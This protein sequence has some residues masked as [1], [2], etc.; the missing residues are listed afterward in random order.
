LIA[1]GLTKRPSAYAI[2]SRDRLIVSRV[3]ATASA[4]AQRFG[5]A[6]GDQAILDGGR[7]GFI[8]KERCEF[9][10]SAKPFLCQPY[11]ETLI[12]MSNF[13]EIR[14]LE[15]LR[16]PGRVVAAYK[17]RG[18]GNERLVGERR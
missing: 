16:T 6:R 18:C 15:S 13:V 11:G 12:S 7:T 1:L 8:P 3:L 2:S 14:P 17:D 10:H 9:P 4:S 5:N